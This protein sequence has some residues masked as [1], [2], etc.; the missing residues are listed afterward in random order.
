MSFITN[1]CSHASLR[2]ANNCSCPSVSWRTVRTSDIKEIYDDGMPRCIP[3]SRR[4]VSWE[5]NVVA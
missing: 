1:P 3:A 2:R 5:S 4:G